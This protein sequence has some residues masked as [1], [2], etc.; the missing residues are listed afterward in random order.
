MSY[1]SPING[2]TA[3]VD[4][5]ISDSKSRSLFRLYNPRANV[6]ILTLSAKYG[7]NMIFI[8]ELYPGDDLQMT[9]EEDKNFISAEMHL[10]ST[11]AGESFQGSEIITP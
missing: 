10:R 4:T 9:T 7:S 6:G 8:A 5:K 11:A 2:I 3:S 1:P